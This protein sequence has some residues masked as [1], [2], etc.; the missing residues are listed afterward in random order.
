MSPEPAEVH[1]MVALTEIHTSRTAA[2]TDREGHPVLLQHKNRSRWD[3]LLIGRSLASLARTEALNQPLG[4]YRQQAQI[5]ACHTRATR[6]ESLRSAPSAC[7]SRPRPWSNSTAP[8]RSSWPT[9][10]QPASPSPG[11]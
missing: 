10:R 6:A 2:R 1:G 7:L 5:A 8:S 3:P 9:A 4:S 11:R